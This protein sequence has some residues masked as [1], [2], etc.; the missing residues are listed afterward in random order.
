MER[1]EFEQVLKRAL[2]LQSLQK[3]KIAETESNYS[4]E[5][6]HSAASRLG[7]SED[8]LEKAISETG[9]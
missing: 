7:I 1:K 5:D 8:I 6:L 2:E 3:N 4:A 9:Q